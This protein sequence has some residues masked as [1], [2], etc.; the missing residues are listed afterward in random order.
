MP[1]AAAGVPARACL[2]CL[3][4]L[5]SYAHKKQKMYLTHI[6]CEPFCKMSRCLSHSCIF[7]SFKLVYVFL[8]VIE[9]IP[10]LHAHQG[11]PNYGPRTNCCEP[12]VAILIFT[13]RW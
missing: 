10:R 12:L 1:V 7:V 2:R 13:T 8:L 3:V 9:D 4:L 6:S 5:N 11:C